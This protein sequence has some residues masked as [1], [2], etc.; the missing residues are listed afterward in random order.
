MFGLGHWELAIVLVVILLL[1]GRR[2]ITI[3]RS[4]GE[5]IGLLGKAADHLLGDNRDDDS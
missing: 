5:S 1:F 3:S 2:C 4:L